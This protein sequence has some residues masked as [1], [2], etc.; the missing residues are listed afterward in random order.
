VT[1][2]TVPFHPDPFPF[3]W[4]VEESGYEWVK[5]H[6]LEWRLTARTSATPQRRLR[7]YI[8]LKGNGLFLKFAAVNPTRNGIKEFANRY[9]LLF[10]KYADTDAVCRRP[11]QYTI[12]QLF[13][14][15][16]RMWRSEIEHMN[17]LVQIWRAV[18]GGQKRK[19][20]KFIVWAGE[21]AVGYEFCGSHVWLAT[22]DIN[23]HLLSRF[24]A[25]DVLRPAIYL[26]QREVNRRIAEN[27]TSAY[28]IVPRLAWC[29]GPR[30]EGSTRPDHH[31]RLVFQP[32]NLLAAMWL[33]FA[34]A[35]TEEYRLR[36]CE[37][38]GEY[39]QVGKGARRMHARTCGDRCRQRLSRRRRDEE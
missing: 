37:G 12:S 25:G 33:Q 2:V 10:D 30:I 13:G 7:P 36:I 34:R 19:L 1:S 27:E 17:L 28:K 39:F 29:P 23:G 32:T 15:S 6:D 35:V 38:C 31:Q 26:L 16:L 4:L 8:P 21:R 3:V 14:T 22:E 18:R 5:G 11:G 20:K 9:G 24:R